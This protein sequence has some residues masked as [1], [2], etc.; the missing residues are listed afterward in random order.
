VN[1]IKHFKKRKHPFE[2]WGVGMTLIELTVVIL[3]LLTLI[4]V[5]FIG[6]QAYKGAANRSSCILNIRNVQQGVRSDQNLKEKQPG[7]SGLVES[8]I[9]GY[10]GIEYLA[11]PTCPAGGTYDFE[12]GTHYPPFGV[13]AIKCSKSSTENHLPKDYSGW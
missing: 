5:L 13:L 7:D 4:T 3:V 11:K 12:A 6:A 10:L 8:E 9:Y 1:S 2:S